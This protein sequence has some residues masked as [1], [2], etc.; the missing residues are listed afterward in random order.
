MAHLCDCEPGLG[1]NLGGNVADPLWYMFEQVFS[2]F[3]QVFSMFEQVF[4]MLSGSD[5]TGMVMDVL[6]RW[7]DSDG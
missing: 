5:G 4:S 7:L 3:E 2:M 6:L 1:G